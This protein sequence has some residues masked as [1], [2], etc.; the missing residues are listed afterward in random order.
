L[1][2]KFPSL[3]GAVF[4]IFHVLGSVAGFNQAAAIPVIAS[5]TVAALEL[6]RGKQR[7]VLLVNLTSRCV[8]VRVRLNR[9][10]VGQRVLDASSAALA[11]QAPERFLA[12]P[13]EA[14]AGAGVSTLALEAFAFAC[15]D[16]A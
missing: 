16:L 13:G 7:R 11:L 14:L 10:T 4:P 2:E 9:G 15:L 5:Q 12:Q 8:L 6:F 1:P 3:P